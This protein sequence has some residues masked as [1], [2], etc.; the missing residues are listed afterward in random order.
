MRAYLID[1]DQ[2]DAPLAAAVVP[3]A[4]TKSLQSRQPARKTKR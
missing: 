4:S 2:P 1:T 3:R